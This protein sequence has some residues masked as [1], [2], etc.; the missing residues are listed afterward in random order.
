M[1]ILFIHE[2]NYRGKVV[3][4]M[5]E[6]PELLALAGHEVHFLEFPEDI[7][8]RNFSLRTRRQTIS[9]KA[10]PEAKVS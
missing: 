6:F 2:V 1:K 5:H 4:E 7:G 9:G 8:I 3:F 10:Y